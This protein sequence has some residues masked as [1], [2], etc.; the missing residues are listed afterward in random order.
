VLS[1]TIVI[2]SLFCTQGR[3]PAE[4]L[5]KSNILPPC[6]LDLRGVPIVNSTWGRAYIMYVYSSYLFTVLNCLFNVYSDSTFVY[7]QY[8]L[9]ILIPRVGLL[10]ALSLRCTSYK[11][12][13]LCTACVDTFNL[14]PG[15]ISLVVP[16]VTST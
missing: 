10:L 3:A 13:Y 5:L 9:I 7:V 2:H 8:A 14:T 6:L 4:R 12:V 16:Y 1:T 15:E 11:C